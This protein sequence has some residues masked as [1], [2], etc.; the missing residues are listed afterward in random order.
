MSSPLVFTL[1]RGPSGVGQ[2]WELQQGGFCGRQDDAAICLADPRVSRRHAEF[3]RAASGWVVRDLSSHGTTLNGVRLQHEAQVPLRVG[4][5]VGIGP[6]VLSV[7]GEHDDERTATL[8]LTSDAQSV[9]SMVSMSSATDSPSARAA[10][11]LRLVLGR[12]AALSSAGSTEAIA[13]T[14]LECML[15]LTRLEW[16]AV[17]EYSEDET[18]TRRVIA[19]H[20]R[21]KLAQVSASLLS[22]ARSGAVSLASEPSLRERHSIVS[23]STHSAVAATIRIG[24]DPVWQVYLASGEGE[25]DSDAE[26]PFY[27]DALAHIAGLV[28]SDRERSELAV[29]QSELQREI[30]VAREVQTRLL[31]TVDEHKDS[32]LRAMVSIPGRGVAGDLVGL[33]R[34][35]QGAV[36]FFI[37][38]VS[39]KGAAAAML[40]A[41]TQAYISS[42]I[43]QNTS[44]ADIATQLNRYLCSVSASSEFVTLWIGSF[45]PERRELQYIDAGHGYAYLRDEQ[46]LRQLNDGGGMP[47]GIAADSVFQDASVQATGEACVLLCSDGI[48]EQQDPSGQ[49]LGGGAVMAVLKT[50][51]I[52]EIQESLLSVL[53]EHAQSDRY[54]DDVTFAIVQI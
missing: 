44:L 52:P 42:L 37:G 13:L 28:L 46:G 47:L 27:V 6:F 12:A 19:D 53:R 1:L 18:A 7:V 2:R 9:N 40:M 8:R 30:A 45:S 29:R 16:G 15:D 54:S 38:D 32:G 35:P 26:S 41:A 22:A 11:R 17:I 50:A 24:D 51:A 25:R 48:M 20:N 31:G 33:R 14:L 21:P 43:D 5:R 39:G 23:S 10:Q 49:E 34:S 3:R 4:D 36:Y